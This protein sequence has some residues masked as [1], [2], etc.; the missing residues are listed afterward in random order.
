MSPDTHMNWASSSAPRVGPQGLLAVCLGSSAC[1]GMIAI[2][3]VH[4]C[5]CMFVFVCVY[6]YVFVHVHLDVRVYVF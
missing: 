2:V 1:D 5:M 3:S 4:V 6:V